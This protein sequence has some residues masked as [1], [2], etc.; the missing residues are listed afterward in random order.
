VFSSSAPKA[1]EY[2][3]D[4]QGQ[5]NQPVTGSVT[6]NT[7]E[8]DVPLAVVGN[9]GHSAAAAKLFGL[10]GYTADIA[11]A[12]P[13]LGI[14]GGTA[15]GAANGSVPFFDNVDQTAPIDV[16]VTGSG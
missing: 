11:G 4:P 15:P 13:M 16:A 14:M 6:G 1:L 10:T 12:L 9:P 3:P 2:V 5:I 8:I 7:I